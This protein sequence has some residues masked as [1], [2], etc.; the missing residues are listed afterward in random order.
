MVCL[1]IWDIKA[2]NSDADGDDDEDD[3]EGG[4]PPDEEEG[5]DGEEA[6]EEVDKTTL[7]YILIN[8]PASQKVNFFAIFLTYVNQFAKNG[9]DE[10]VKRYGATVHSEAILS[11]YR[12]LTLNEG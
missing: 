2:D 8:C 3:E 7:K 10:A 6:V 9:Y 5:A 1:S 11:I 12:N 4:P